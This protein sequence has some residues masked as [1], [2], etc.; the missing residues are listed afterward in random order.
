MVSIRLPPP[1]HPGPASSM[2]R[3]LPEGEGVCPFWAKTGLARERGE[4]EVRR[5]LQGASEVGP[6]PGG[7]DPYKVQA[8]L[9]LRPYRR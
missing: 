1:P 5:P 4:S 9:P 3:D 7:S 6:M 8:I 2:L